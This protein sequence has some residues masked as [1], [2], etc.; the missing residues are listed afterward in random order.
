MA[1]LSATEPK[2]WF[3]FGDPSR[4]AEQWADDILPIAR[5][6][7]ARVRFSHV[8]RE[9]K[10]GRVFAQGEAIEVGDGYREWATGVV[11]QELH[12]AGWRLAIW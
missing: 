3:S 4:W 11:L 7:H 1:R 5:E 9:E 2:Q 10:E 6:A 12:R 8:H